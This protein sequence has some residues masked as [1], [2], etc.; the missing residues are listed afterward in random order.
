VSGAVEVASAADVAPL[1]NRIWITVTLCCLAATAEGFD[2]QSMGVAA[3]GMAPA[4]HL[5]R[6]QLGPAFSASTVGL[7][8]GAILIGALADRIGRKWALIASLAV[9]GAF[10]LWTPYAPDLPSLLVVRA[11]AGLGLGGAMPNFVA[12]SGECVSEP[13][14]AQFAAISGAAMPLGGAAASGLAA[15]LPWRAIFQVGG[16]WPLVLAAVM[17]L[18]LPESARFL[19]ARRAVGASRV[20]AGVALFGGGRAISSLLLWIAAFCALLILF[21]MLNWL[22]LLLAA[23]GVAKPDAAIVQL[24]FNLGGA[25][26]ALGVAWLFYGSRRAA[27]LGVWFAG[28]AAGVVLLALSPP[29][30]LLSALAGLAAGTFV[31]STPTALYA[32]SADFYA[33][34][35]R[36][37][38]LGGVIGVG[39]I[40]AVLGPLLAGALLAHGKDSTGVL[41]ALPPFVAIGA[42]ATFLALPRRPAHIA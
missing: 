39:R 11:L 40:G 22:P 31:S 14:R 9:F 29:T 30:L 5:T 21:V 35:M 37:T 6:D 2:I 36:A 27:T 23:K 1:A 17:A 42:L 25:V 26:G 24:A 7:L 15:L 4:L 13:R 10:S 19:A 8:F 12:L 18:A 3:P 41:M 20:S 38:G 34:E 16:V 33:V 28:T 32:L